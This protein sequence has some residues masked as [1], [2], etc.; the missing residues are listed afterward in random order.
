VAHYIQRR[1][2]TNIVE[3]VD[4]F[5]TAKE[6]YKA[7]REYNLSDTTAVHYVAIPLP[8]IIP[9]RGAARTQL[10]HHHESTSSSS[11]WLPSAPDDCL[12]QALL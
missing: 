3:T 5:E 8:L 1:D 9:L 11:I 12:H 7:A 6:A 10:L 4:E 2:H